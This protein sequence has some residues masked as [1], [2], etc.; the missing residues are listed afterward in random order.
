MALRQQDPIRFALL[1]VSVLLLSICLP[2]P[3]AQAQSV[4]V[5]IPDKQIPSD[6]VLR[7]GRALRIQPASFTFYNPGVT[8]GNHPPSSVQLG[9]GALLI[10][11]HPNN[12]LR[13]FQ[14]LTPEAIA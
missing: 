11:F 5:L 8:G 2:L 7:C 12:A 3:P 10:D 1:T 6:R 9:S 13:N 14:V 4:C